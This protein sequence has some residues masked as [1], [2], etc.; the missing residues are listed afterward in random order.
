MNIID[1]LWSIRNDLTNLS[2]VLEAVRTA[3]AEA[4]D[5]LPIAGKTLRRANLEQPSFIQRYED[6]KGSLQALSDGLEVRILQQRAKVLRMISE[7]SQV[8]YGERMMSQ[9]AEED[10]RLVELKHMRVDVD[11]VLASA[12]AKCEAFRQRG[13]TLK[14]LTDLT[15]AQAMDI[16][17]LDS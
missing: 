2:P 14:N 11:E 4:E 8:S 5:E 15:V 7:E 16:V 10:P 13:F 3:L 9:L 12:K 6:I 17:L 1:R